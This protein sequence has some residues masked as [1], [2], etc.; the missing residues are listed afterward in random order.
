MSPL[1]PVSPLMSGGLYMGAELIAKDKTH[2]LQLM[3]IY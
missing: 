1:A 2:A 3:P